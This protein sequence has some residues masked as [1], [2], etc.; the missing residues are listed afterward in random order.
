[1]TL[2]FA[3]DARI[4]KLVYSCKHKQTGLP[5]CIPTIMCKVSRRVCL[6]FAIFV[7]NFFLSAV[8]MCEYCTNVQEL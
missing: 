6:K 5:A 4:I 8:I 2:I 7:D 1:M 3:E